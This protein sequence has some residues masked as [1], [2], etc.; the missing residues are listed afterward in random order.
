MTPNFGTLLPMLEPVL[1]RL[2][3]VPF[4]QYVNETVWIFAIVETAHLLFLAM[5]GGAVLGL[6]LRLL[7]VALRDVSVRDVERWT[8]PLLIVGAAG[9][10][11]TGVAM[12]ITTART[13]VPSS[14][15]FIKMVA[16]VGAI[17][18]SLAISRVVARGE[19]APIGTN[20]ALG[21]GGAVVWAFAIL[22]FATNAHISVGAL[23]VLGAGVALLIVTARRHRWPLAGGLA[24]LAI[25]VWFSADLIGAG[26]EQGLFAGAFNMGAVAAAI[27][28]TIGAGAF[29]YS[30]ERTEGVSVIKI[31]AFTSTLAWL[32]VAAAGRW[33]GFS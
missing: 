2:D 15:F 26:D 33:I 21:L 7:E 5:L 6:N 12:G 30:S 19:D 4:L 31:G 25:G 24:A 8:R 9:T 16:L 28:L 22:L 20:G 29:E 23:L 3:Q 11:I 10:I 27:P 1:A 32:T 17:L 14:A 13:L 18:I